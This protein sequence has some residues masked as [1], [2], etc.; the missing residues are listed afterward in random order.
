[1]VAS[2]AERGRDFMLYALAATEIA[3]GCRDMAPRQA[4]M[5]LAEDWLDLAEQLLRTPDPNLLH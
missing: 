3:E 4:Y 1:M 2:N 5:G